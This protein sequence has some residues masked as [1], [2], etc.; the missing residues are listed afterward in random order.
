[1]RLNIIIMNTSSGKI[2]ERMEK[3][4]TFN[5]ENNKKMPIIER[6]KDD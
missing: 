3:F 4:S 2:H 1:M 5:T 6:K